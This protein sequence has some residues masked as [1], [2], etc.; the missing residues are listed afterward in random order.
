MAL[1]LLPSIDDPETGAAPPAVLPDAAP[2]PDFSGQPVSTAAS[3]GVP[4]TRD[5]ALAAPLPPQDAGI[6]AGA[7]APVAA[8]EIPDPALT[9]DGIPRAD[10]NPLAKSFGE[11]RWDVMVPGSWR[12]WDEEWWRQKGIERDLSTPEMKETFGIVLDKS[13]PLMAGDLD[14]FEDVERE[15]THRIVDKFLRDSTGRE[16]PLG[17]DDIQRKM[18]I[19]E[20]AHRFFDGRGAESEVALKGEIVSAA[21]ADRER[22]AAEYKARFAVVSPLLGEYIGTSARAQILAGHDPGVYEKVK[23]EL[24]EKYELRSEVANALKEADGDPDRAIWMLKQKVAEESRKSSSYRDPYNPFSAPANLSYSLAADRNGKTIA[25]LQEMQAEFDRMGIPREQRANYIRD[26]A[27]ATAWTKDTNDNIR[28]GSD[29][30]IY[31]NPGQVFGKREA[32][33]AEIN[34]S[35]ASPD[36]KHEAIKRLDLMRANMADKMDEILRRT[37][38][39]QGDEWKKDFAAA[40]PPARLVYGSPGTESYIRFVKDGGFSNKVD[41][42]D[43]YAKLQNDRNYLFRFEDAITVGIQ[44]GIVGIAKTTVGAGAGLSGVGGMMG[45]DT[46]KE[47]SAGLGRKQMELGDVISDLDKASDLRGNTGEL[48]VAKDFSNSLTQILPMLAGGQYAAGLGKLGSVVVGGMA[49]YGTT[50]AQGYESITGSA[51]EHARRRKGGDL[52]DDEIIGVLGDRRVQAGAFVNAI[53]SAALAKLM[54][55]GTERAA[56]GRLHG[57]TLRDILSRGGEGLFRDPAF[58]K[59]MGQLAKN[60]FADAS[61]EA[62]EGFLNTATEHL[63]RAGTLDQDVRL[64]DLLQDAAYST[65]FDGPTGGL[66]PQ[67]RHGGKFYQNISDLKRFPGAEVREENGIFVL[68]YPDIVAFSPSINGMLTENGTLIFGIKT[69][70]KDS[71]VR[72]A[73]MFNRMITHFGDRVKSIQGQWY[74]YDSENPDRRS[75]L[76]TFNKFIKEGKIPEEAALLTFTGKMAGRNGFKDVKILESRGKKGEYT[77]VKVEFKKRYENHSSRNQRAL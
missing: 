44:T 75:N 35:S 5:E 61:D 48:A 6:T 50:A 63:V 59:E 14:S 70:E 39:T 15:N 62:I 54:P 71:P 29:L 18:L 43:A 45:S 16:V 69:P 7:S 4:L 66:L 64:G 28:L 46:A 41:A 1:T 33:V 42:L 19:Q 68:D 77:R 13:L 58:R 12:E 40:V 53:Q 32:V 8:P 51:L 67:V 37:D 72:G 21:E 23:G 22:T 31:I 57:T 73:D 52:T 20:A 27:K 76:Y 60:I 17:A 9:R 47:W 30:R 10:E 2:V 55:G 25:R 49:V 24:N 74:E 36:E 26:T 3:A 56:L 34:A 11:I 65:L 38:A